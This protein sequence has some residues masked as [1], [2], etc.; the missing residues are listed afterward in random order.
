MTHFAYYGPKKP[1][2]RYK[3]SHPSGTKSQ[4]IQEGEQMLNEKL[5]HRFLQLSGIPLATLHYVPI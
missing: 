2:I 5:S 3:L 4:S 1:N